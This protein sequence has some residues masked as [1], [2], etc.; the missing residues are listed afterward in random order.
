MKL[1]FYYPYKRVK[2]NILPIKG[3]HLIVVDLEITESHSEF[4]KILKKHH[5]ARSGQPYLPSVLPIYLF[6]LSWRYFAQM[7]QSTEWCLILFVTMPHG[8]I[9]LVNLDRE[10]QWKHTNQMKS[11]GG[12]LCFVCV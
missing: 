12:K 10:L 2:T 6:I 7:I 5:L 9:T 8:V 1:H 4:N 11:L 3:Y